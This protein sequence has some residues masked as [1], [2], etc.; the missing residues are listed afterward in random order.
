[1]DVLFIVY[2]LSGYKLMINATVIFVK[3]SQTLLT[4]FAVESFGIPIH[5]KY[6]FVLLKF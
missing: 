3:Y 5:L 2:V 6:L 4:A 1:M